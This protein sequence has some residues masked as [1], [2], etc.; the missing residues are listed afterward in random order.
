M[1]ELMLIR[2]SSD[3]AEQIAE[4]RQAFLDAGDSMDGTG[5]LRKLADPKEYIKNCIACEDPA[6][7]PADLVSATQLLLIRKN[8]DKLLGMIQIRH[9]FND[10]LEKFGGHIGYSVKPSERRKG[11]A[12]KMLEMALPFCKQLGLKKVLITCN[13][14]N[15]GSEKTILDNGGIYESINNGHTLILRLSYSPLKPHNIKRDALIKHPH[16]LLYYLFISTSFFCSFFMSI[17]YTGFKILSYL[18]SNIS[19]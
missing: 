13:D 5:A 4:Y 18:S 19:L 12:K 6:T 1:E 15:I 9:D 11:Y 14:N 10:Y 7:V 17:E 2:P 16:S 3:Y 8:D